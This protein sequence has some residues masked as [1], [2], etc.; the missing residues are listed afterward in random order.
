LREHLG[1][2]H[3]VAFITDDGPRQH[4]AGTAA[5][6]LN[7]A[8]HDQ[9]I[10][11]GRV[12]AGQRRQGEQPHAEQ[13]RL[14]STEAIG[15]RPIGQL[16]ER[17]TEEVRSQRGLYMFLVG[18][19]RL[20]HGREGGQVEVDRQGPERTQCAQDQHHSQVH[21]ESIAG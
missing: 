2:G 5:Q 3:R 4:H 9:R 17:Q 21:Q 13:Q 10:E 1:R 8:R 7:E 15:H 6:G 20:R 11:V 18:G 14:T 12:G 16:A 19:E